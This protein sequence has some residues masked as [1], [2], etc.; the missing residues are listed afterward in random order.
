MGYFWLSL[1]MDDIV[2][3]RKPRKEFGFIFCGITNFDSR[4]FVYVYIAPRTEE[5]KSNWNG[6]PAHAPY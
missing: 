3:L 5:P 2:R 6:L 1:K 4:V